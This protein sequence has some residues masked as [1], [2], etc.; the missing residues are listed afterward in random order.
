MSQTQTSPGDHLRQYKQS[1]LTTY[2]IV[3]GPSHARY[4]SKRT[5][6]TV[7][8]SRREKNSGPHRPFTVL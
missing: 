8:F 3:A 4:V 6:H 2:I 1:G 7:V 5:L